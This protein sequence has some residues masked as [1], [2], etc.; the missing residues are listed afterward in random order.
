MSRWTMLLGT[1]VLT[2]AC[3]ANDA[4]LS[5]VGKGVG[6]TVEEALKDSFRDAV[7]RAV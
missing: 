2:F 5:S 3:T 1:V 7:E 4:I 6:V